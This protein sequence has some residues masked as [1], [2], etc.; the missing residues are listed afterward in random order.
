MLYEILKSLHIVAVIVWFGGTMAGALFLS[1]AEP[2]SIAK[3]TRF[4]RVIT[5]PAMGLAWIFGLWM[6]TAYGWFGS[7]WLT[8]KLVFVVALS[9]IH[10][11]VSGRL[12]RTSREGASNLSKSTRLALPSMIACMCAIVLLVV[13]K[14]F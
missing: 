5:T 11:I 14:P 1:C 2:N 8:A 13:T 9:A 10:G 4:D 3:I 7:G 12:K 6:A